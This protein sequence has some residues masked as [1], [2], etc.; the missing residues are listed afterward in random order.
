MFW[1]VSLIVL[2]RV[3]DFIA[4]GCYCGICLLLIGYCVIVFGISVVCLLDSSFANMM[5]EFGYS[6]LVL[7]CLLFVIL[8]LISCL[9][10]LRLLCWIV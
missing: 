9:L 10:W 1:N 7:C 2:L 5:L 8:L 3:F 4:V 6:L